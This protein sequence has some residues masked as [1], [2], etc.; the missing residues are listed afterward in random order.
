MYVPNLCSE[1]PQRTD[2]AKSSLGYLPGHIHAFWLIYKKM[3]AEER[4]GNGGFQCAYCNYS[5]LPPLPLQFLSDRHYSN[6]TLTDTTSRNQML[7]AANTNPS[8]QA[9][10]TILKDTMSTRSSKLLTTGPLVSNQMAFPPTIHT[11]PLSFLRMNGGFKRWTDTSHHLDPRHSSR[12]PLASKLEVGAAYPKSIFMTT[13]S[14]LPEHFVSSS[15][16]FGLN[17]VNESAFDVSFANCY[18]TYLY[19]I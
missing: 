7:A 10:T 2:V 9:H 8:T 13:I 11:L 6:V 1:I 5:Y 15:Y 17:L 16:L 14:F 4:Y 18:T 3:Q 19:L 12:F